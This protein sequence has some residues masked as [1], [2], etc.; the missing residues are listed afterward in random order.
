MISLI[1]HWGLIHLSGDGHGGMPV[2][3][4]KGDA[5]CCCTWACC[6]FPFPRLWPLPFPLCFPFVRFRA[7]ELRVLYSILDASPVG[8]TPNSR[9]NR[10]LR[11]IG[12]GSCRAWS[13]G[14]SA[15]CT[16][17][18]SRSPFCLLFRR[19][20]STEMIATNP[21]LLLW[22]AEWIARP[23]NGVKSRFF[24]SRAAVLCSKWDVPLNVDAKG[25]LLWH[26]PA[27][28]TSSSPP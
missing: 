27:L 2:W 24:E 5:C 26:V 6:A 1:N 23:S 7:L 11:P 20:T 3:F 21:S 12:M 25:F 9:W 28:I 19:D 15:F 13:H 8:M 22:L 17:G 4:I 18:N 16:R 14:N 10:L